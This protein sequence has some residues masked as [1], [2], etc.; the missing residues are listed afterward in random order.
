MAYSEFFRKKM[1]KTRNFAGPTEILVGPTEIFLRKY[2]GGTHKISHE[3]IH[4]GPTLKRN[5]LELK[6]AKGDLFGSR[7]KKEVG[8]GYK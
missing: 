7:K 8:L 6:K 5:L 1:P 4:V 3:N 2:L